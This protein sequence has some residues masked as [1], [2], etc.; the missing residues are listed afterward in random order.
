[1]DKATEAKEAKEAKDEDD[2]D[3]EDDMPLSSWLKSQDDE[4]K[5]RRQ[6]DAKKR[7]TVTTRPALKGP[8]LTHATGGAQGGSMR[9]DESVKKMVSGWVYRF[10]NPFSPSNIHTL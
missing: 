5:R 3:D 2:E 10:R 4:A 6:H 8:Q 7:K 1:M 9:P